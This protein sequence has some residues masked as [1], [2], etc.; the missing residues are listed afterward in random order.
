L[1]FRGAR[2]GLQGNGT[3][4]ATVLDAQLPVAVFV[5]ANV[6][7]LLGK[8]HREHTLGRRL[9]ARIERT[10]AV[11]GAALI[12][13][14]LP[15][16]PGALHVH[17]TEVVLTVRVVVG[18]ERR[19][20]RDRGEQLRNERRPHCLDTAGDE[21]PSTALIETIA[22]QGI[23]EPGDALRPRVHGVPF[24]RLGERSGSRGKP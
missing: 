17:S 8:H 12:V 13:V 22:S 1:K 19:E 7:V 14:D 11:V 15:E 21:R 4:I 24:L 23:V 10:L 5:G 2:C 6:A 18:T 20:V 9:V 16:A 3:A